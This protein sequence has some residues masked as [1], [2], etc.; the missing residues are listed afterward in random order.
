MITLAEALEAINK[1]SLPELN[2]FMSEGRYGKVEYQGD[3]ILINIQVL[4]KREKK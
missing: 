2:K 1:A 4:K 3:K